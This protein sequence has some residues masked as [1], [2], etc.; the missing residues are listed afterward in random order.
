[1][2]EENYDEDDPFTGIE[3]FLRTSIREIQRDIQF[4]TNEE[5]RVYMRNLLGQRQ[6]DLLDLYTRYGV[7]VEE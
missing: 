5:V 2:A 6:Q 7:A 4:V 1:M 3:K